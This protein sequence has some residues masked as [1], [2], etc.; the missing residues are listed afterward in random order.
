MVDLAA[1][2]LIGSEELCDRGFGKRWIA[3]LRTFL[4]GKRSGALGLLYEPTYPCQGAHRIRHSSI[5]TM[6]L[7]GFGAARIT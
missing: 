1:A 2:T 7:A 5:D 4:G 6:P 3:V